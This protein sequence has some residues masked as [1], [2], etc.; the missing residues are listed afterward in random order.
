MGTA[1]AADGRPVPLPNPTT[2]PFFDAAREER[3]LLPRCPRDGF[4]FYP[5]SRCPGCLGDDWEWH[6]ASG[7][8][9]VHACTVDRIG[10]DGALASRAP[11][12]IAVVELEEGPRMTAGISSCAPDDVR[13]GM[14]VQAAWEHL[15]EVSLVH[16]TPRGPERK[17]G[18]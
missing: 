12:A 4:F 18:A 14:P 16:F 9:V 7:R 10:H 13:V 11:F 3:L 5:R 6:E 1:F 17:P 8:G 15:E 2:Q